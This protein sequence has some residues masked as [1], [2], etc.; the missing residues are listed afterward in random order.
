MVSEGRE[1]VAH[2]AGAGPGVE[3]RCS[4]GEPHV[5]AK[6]PGCNRRGGVSPTQHAP[7]VILRPAIVDLCSLLAALGTERALQMLGPAGITQI[8]A[9]H[10]P[11]R[12]F[13]CSLPLCT[14]VRKP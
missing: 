2:H 4:V 7:L 12:P 6:E 9:F 5:A 10:L 1:D 14:I 11:A 8:N 3:N 13:D